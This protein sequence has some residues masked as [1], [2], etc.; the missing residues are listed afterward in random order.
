M[1]WHSLVS[2][3]LAL[4]AVIANSCGSARAADD[5]AGLVDVGGGRSLYVNCQ[6][7]GSPTVLIIPGKGS[8]AEAWNVVVPTDDPIRSSPYDVIG[9]AKLEPSPTATQPVVA[10]TTR[11]CAYDRPNT[12]PDGVDRST[13]SAQPH[14]VTQD[15]DD[16]VTLLSALGISTPVVV[17][18]HSY[19]G[20]VAD[21]LARTH[22]Q[23]LS[24]LVLVDPV[25]EF[26]LT[27]GEPEQNA[28]FNRDAAIPAN[29]DGEGFL[30]D[31]AYAAIS[32]APPLPKVPAMVLS[33][34]KFPPPTDLTP[35]NYTL[36]Q[37]QQ[38]NT[39][40]ADALGTVNVTATNSGHNLMLYR[41]QLVADQIVAVVNQVRLQSV[42]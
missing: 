26:L 33:S 14:P 38:A 11:V 22:S 41:P 29:P 17:V 32:A 36:R 1:R 12:R 9:Q 39:L 10:R 27:Q 37:I 16:I 35:D 5:F 2:I 4:A 3:L 18:A 7:T 24:G 40:L 31:D 25:S 15:V 28:A 13:P 20:L 21:L 23:L 19:G 6:G 34:D 42:G 30:A 8:Y